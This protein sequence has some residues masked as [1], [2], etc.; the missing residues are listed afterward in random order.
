M[1]GAEPGE[2]V[3]T[4]STESRTAGGDTEEDGETEDAEKPRDDAQRRHVPGGARHSQNQALGNLTA[5]NRVPVATVTEQSPEPDG[6]YSGGTA[7]R[8]VNPEV[9]SDTDIR[10]RDARGEEERRRTARIRE[11]GG[12]E[13]GERV[14]TPSTESRTAGGDTEEDGETD[15]EDAEKPRDNAQRR[16]VPGGAWHSQV[17][18]Y[19]IVKILPEWMQV[20][21]KR[22]KGSEEPGRDREEGS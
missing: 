6:P 16:H 10:E 18:A 11:M 22:E 15:E 7:A 19:L 5:C 12:A 8:G 20:D 3:S 1:G 14:S 13:P 17:R 2:R 21:K 4:P 9:E